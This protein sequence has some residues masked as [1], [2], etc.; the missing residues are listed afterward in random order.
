MASSN[1]M[2]P[3]NGIIISEKLSKA[4]HAMWRAQVLTAVRGSRLTG[5]LTGVTPTPAMEVATKVD[6]KDSK[7]PNLAYDD[8]FATDQQV[9]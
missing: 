1:P 6:G 5:H 9:L 3:F 8:W 4:N 7:V 2:N